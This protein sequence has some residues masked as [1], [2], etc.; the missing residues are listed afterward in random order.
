MRRSLPSSAAHS[1]RHARSSSVRLGQKRHRREYI[2]Q[3]PAKSRRM[4]EVHLSCCAPL[5]TL[6][7]M[8]CG[9][10]L[11][12]VANL[13]ACDLTH[14]EHPAARAL[15][16]ALALAKDS[17]PADCHPPQL[18]LL[19]DPQD[20]RPCLA[21]QMVF[22]QKDRGACGI[23]AS[24]GIGTRG[25]YWVADGRGPFIILRSDEALS[26]D[27]LGGEVVHGDDRVAGCQKS[28]WVFLIHHD[29]KFGSVVEGTALAYRAACLEKQRA[30]PLHL[31]EEQRTN[32]E[33]N[34]K[35]AAETANSEE[36]TDTD[37]AH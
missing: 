15:D 7:L 5:A 20:R 16:D 33:R 23:E 27:D 10:L 32:L 4:L 35:G 1:I 30:R 31:T 34:L 2:A 9:V 12:L 3:P 13:C 37:N 22:A 18:E 29:P 25:T 14:R 26:C 8:R 6:G 11:L 36:S 24:Y 19:G 28:G 21:S 17:K